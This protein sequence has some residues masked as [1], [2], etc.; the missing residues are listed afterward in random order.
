M[1][2]RLISEDGEIY[3]WRNVD[4]ITEGFNKIYLFPPKER[5]QLL[6]LYHS[7]SLISDLENTHH[8][9]DMVVIDNND[10][11]IERIEIVVERR[12]LPFDTYDISNRVR[13]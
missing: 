7:E 12:L 1:K 8:T 13:T 11:C 9:T 3:E 6:I 4:T 2:V 5:E 10:M